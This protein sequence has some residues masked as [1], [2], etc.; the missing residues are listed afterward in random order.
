MRSI[1]SGSSTS[2]DILD[3]VSHCPCCCWTH[4][5]M[6]YRTHN[7]SHT[8]TNLLYKPCINSLQQFTKKGQRKK[9]YVRLS[10]WGDDFIH[11][12][13]IPY[14]RNIPKEIPIPPILLNL[15]KLHNIFG[16]TETLSIYSFYSLSLLSI[17]YIT[18]PSKII[19]TLRLSL[20]ESCA[21]SH[22]YLSKPHSFILFFSL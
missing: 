2:F 3:D 11:W 13:K 7:G 22:F 6:A 1:S 15:S 8:W 19:W 14:Q 17:L 10:Q 21:Q 5:L 16:I 4:T 20:Q 12:C 9:T 18:K